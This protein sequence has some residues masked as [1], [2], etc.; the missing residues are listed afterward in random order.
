MIEYDDVS[1]QDYFNL[2][3]ELEVAEQEIETLKADNKV[4][5]CD[6]DLAIIEIGKMQL[7]IIDFKIAATKGGEIK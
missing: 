5:K 2:G 6:H 3:K 4:L 1:G 7:E